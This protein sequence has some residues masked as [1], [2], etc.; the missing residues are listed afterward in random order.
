V[1]EF[2]KAYA[3]FLKPRGTL[4]LFVLLLIMAI[5]LGLIW[6]ARSWNDAPAPY[7]LF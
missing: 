5:L 3:A 6:V 2:L 1:K 4:L 7:V